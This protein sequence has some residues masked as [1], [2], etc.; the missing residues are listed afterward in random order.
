MHTKEIL[1]MKLQD[2]YTLIDSELSDILKNNP[3]YKR[4]HQNKQGDKAYAFLIWFL[5]FYGQKAIYNQYIT[6]G[7]DDSSCDIIFSNTDLEG[8]KIFYVVQAKWNNQSNANS[9]FS[10]E[11][12]KA[13]LNDF[14]YILSGQKELTRNLNFNKKYEELKE[15][16]EANGEV[17]FIYLTLAHNNPSVN[18]TIEAFEKRNNFPVEIIDIDRL[19]RDYIEIKYK[20]IKPTNPLEYDY[21]PE[22]EP[23]ILP[24]EQLEIN[25]N[26]LEVK[27]PFESYIFLVRPKTIHDLFEKYGF[28]LFFSNIRNPLITSDYN[29]EI[30]GSLK[31]NPSY[32][33]YFNN[34]ITAI[35]QSPP[36]KINDIS[37]TIEITGLQVINGAQTVY[38][39]YKAYQS[40]KNG[41]KNVINDNALIT[42]RLIRGG[43]KDFE[44]DVTRYTNQQNEIEPRYFW[45]NDPTQIRLQNES[46]K[47][48]FWYEI[49]RGEFRNKPKNIKEINNVEFAKSYLS[50]YL[51]MPYL[52][53]EKLFFVSVK[54]DNK[55]LYEFIFNDKTRFEDML[56]VYKLQTLLPIA[57]AFSSNKTHLIFGL[58]KTVFEKL[59]SPEIPFTRELNR[60]LETEQGLVFLTKIQLFILTNLGIV[61]GKGNALTK[62]IMAI[63]SKVKF[64]SRKTYF[65]NLL[66]SKEDIDKIDIEESINYLKG[67]K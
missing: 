3:Q 5:Q 25:S 35:T 56:V 2:F 64:E 54:E 66:I 61:E 27:N 33:W 59:K 44:L 30:E 12:F 36:R 19:R 18:E 51:Q 57:S 9:K 6:E 62:I 46:F 40:A 43:N 26:Y 58:F 50:I 23:I 15:H 45:A 17:K 38:S 10:S 29:K 22:I 53:D 49:R 11:P 41:E 20:L 34:G 55:G 1:E 21:N 28:K 39:I 63:S 67:S 31:N 65:E 52:A 32:F 14:Q 60:L 16:L 48:D 42:F 13:T 47:T 7:D 24:I 8:R 37:K 4:L